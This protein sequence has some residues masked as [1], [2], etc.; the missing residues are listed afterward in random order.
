[1]SLTK[2]M[3]SFRTLLL[4]CKS[5]LFPLLHLCHACRWLDL[6]TEGEWEQAD[7]T[8]MEVTFC[9]Y[10]FPHEVRLSLQQLVLKTVPISISRFLMCRAHESHMTNRH[11]HHSTQH[12][13]CN[14]VMPTGSG[15]GPQTTRDQNKYFF[16]SLG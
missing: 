5:H 2:W 8:M 15:K 14:T 4:F 16:G 3:T 6:T 11:C 9:L 12:S 10:L 13:L 7:S 1:M